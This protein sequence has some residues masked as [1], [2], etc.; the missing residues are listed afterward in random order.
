MYCLSGKFKPFLINSGGVLASLSDGVSAYFDLTLSV[1]SSAS[2]KVLNQVAEGV[3]VIVGAV[4]ALETFFFEFDS[5][6]RGFACTSLPP[7]EFSKLL[8]DEE[9]QRAN[10]CND[11][12]ATVYTTLATFKNVSSFYFLGVY[13]NDWFSELI[14]VINGTH[15]D[16]TE[17][18]DFSI[19]KAGVCL[20]V[21]A[22]LVFPYDRISEIEST[23]QGIS[24]KISWVKDYPRF[25]RY[26]NQCWVAAYAERMAYPLVLISPSTIVQ[27][28]SHPLG[29][30]GFGIYYFVV[31]ASGVAMKRSM[32]RFEQ[33]LIAHNFIATSDELKSHLL[34]K[35]QE[36]IN[37]P[38]LMTLVVNWTAMTALPIK[39]GFKKHTQLNSLQAST[40]AIACSLPSTTVKVLALAIERESSLEQ[41]QTRRQSVTPTST[42]KT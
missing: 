30:I 13:I 34:T 4:E 29:A 10:A 38:L 6:K 20:V 28:G 19:W 11:H 42:V 8:D 21:Y 37:L 26:G 15:Q 5:V 40:S 7:D 25:C 31:A 17:L 23:R 12:K 18:D 27:H 24:G 35:S 39:S 9:L 32:R 3:G 22:L 2:N 33:E 36:K 16:T 41:E 14:D 1:A